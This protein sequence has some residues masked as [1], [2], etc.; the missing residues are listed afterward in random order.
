MK[1]ILL[2]LLIGILGGIVSPVFGVG[3]GIVMVP[4]FTGLG[5]PH[6]NPDARGAVFGLTR[7]TGKAEMVRAALESVAYQTHDV[8]DAMRADGG[9]FSR[10]RV[11]G[12]MANNNWF[13]QFLGD[14]LDIPIDRPTNTE[15]TALGAAYLAGM[16]AGLYDSLEGI[17]SA[18]SADRSFS[19]TMETDQRQALLERWQQAVALTGQF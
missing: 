6:W 19:P 18:W 3:G 10:L 17:R 14:I 16:Q 1:L 8:L 7:D 9:E 4:A 11:D 2:A 13:C 5:A 15:T 12:G